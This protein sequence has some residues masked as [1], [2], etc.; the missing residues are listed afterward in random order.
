MKENQSCLPVRKHIS[1]PVKELT[2]GIS[3]LAYEKR[4]VMLIP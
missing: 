4:D 1:S 3:Q 2:L